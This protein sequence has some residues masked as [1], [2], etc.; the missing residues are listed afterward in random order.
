M[1]SMNAREFLQEFGSTEAEKVAIAAGSNLAYFSQLACGARRPS[2]ELAEKLVTASDGRL[3]VLAL[4]REKDKRLE[5][6]RQAADTAG[7]AA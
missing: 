6:K 2:F 7:R 1:W 4:M 3:D 5:S